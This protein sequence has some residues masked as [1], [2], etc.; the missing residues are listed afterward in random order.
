[1]AMYVVILYNCIISSLTEKSYRKADSL[2][3]SLLSNYHLY[4]I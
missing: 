2:T 4:T 3:G 1:M